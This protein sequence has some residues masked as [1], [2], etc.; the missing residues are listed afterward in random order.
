[1]SVIAHDHIRDS[2]FLLLTVCMIIAHTQEQYIVE[3]DI[4][5]KLSLADV[6][7]DQRGYT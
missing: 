2:F 1:M 3:K 7:I 4:G 6:V 5:R